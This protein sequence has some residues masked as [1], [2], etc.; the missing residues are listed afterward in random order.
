MRSPMSQLIHIFRDIGDLAI[1]LLANGEARRAKHTMDDRRTDGYDTK[2]ENGRY[3]I[4]HH[5][6]QP[7]YSSFHIMHINIYCEIA[8]VRV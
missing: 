2:T 4:E 1:V 6:A 8:R 5:T 7:E 3:T